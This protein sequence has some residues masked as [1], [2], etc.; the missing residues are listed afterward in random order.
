M[1]YDYY[2]CTYNNFCFSIMSVQA[3][4]IISVAIIKLLP[5]IY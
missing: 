4:I 3:L 5:A 1:D 2:R